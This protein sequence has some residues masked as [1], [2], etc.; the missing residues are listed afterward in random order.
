MYDVDDSIE[1]KMV[2]KNECDVDYEINTSNFKE[3]S[4]F[5]DYTLTSEDNSKTIKSGESKSFILKVVYSHELSDSDFVKNKYVENNEAGIK[6][7]SGKVVNPYTRVGIPL[8]VVLLL[9][10]SLVACLIIYKKMRV[11]KLFFLLLL[12]APFILVRAICEVELNVDSHVYI[13]RFKPK[14]CN[15]EMSGKDLKQGDEFVDGQYKYRYR[16]QLELD[17]IPDGETWTE[18]VN[19]DLDG[20][21]VSLVDEK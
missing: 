1:Y 9:I 5:L 2:I 13:G 16:Q 14:M 19:M 4:K 6:L 7:L 18:W 8:I 12:L 3:L 20:W 17:Y 10:I 11:N 21:G 15:F